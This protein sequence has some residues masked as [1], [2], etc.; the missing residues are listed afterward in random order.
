MENLSIFIALIEGTNDLIH[1]VSSDGSFDFVNR[2]WLETLG[3]TGNEIKDV[4]LKNILFPGHIKKHQ[5]LIDE[6]FK[7][8]IF[9]DVN[10]T[11]I[12]KTGDVIYCVGNIFPH[13]EGKEITAVHGFF[14]NV[15]E[16]KAT[17][18]QLSEAK[19]RTDFF[20]DLMVH[21][22]TNI[23][24]EIL[25]TFEIL[26][27]TP[28]F[29]KNLASFVDEG[30]TEMERASNLISNVRKITRLYAKQRDEQLI[31]VSDAI[32]SAEEKV[33]A[34]FPKRKLMLTTTLV[35]GQYSIMA[36]EFLDD[37][38][39]SLIHNAMKF[40]KRENVRV[41]VNVELVRFT[42]FVRIQFKDHGSGISDE[43]K[44]EIFS[45]ISHRRE[46]IMGL[47]LGLTLVKKIIET[48]GGYISVQDTVE[49]D[50][51]KG[52]T[53]TIL[54]RYHKPEPGKDEEEE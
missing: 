11:F 4:R 34:A 2:A 26:L 43:E 45:Q 42:P 13:K 22:I 48:Y 7:G 29:P 1:S 47:G 8:K 31:D 17:L 50:S 3:Y 44:E 38:F 9:S 33:K 54:L 21:D 12:T 23:H 53:F 49:G 51:S 46:S 14:R 6:A 20:V 40:D 32:R 25:S 16:E 10:V 28:E 37:V 24:Q 52:A 39:Y 27:L 41:E 18:E 15:T 36:D 30:L 5:D 19:T 35:S